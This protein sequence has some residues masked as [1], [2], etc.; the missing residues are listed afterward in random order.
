MG[1]GGL[2]ALGKVGVQQFQPDILTS[3]ALR[4]SVREGL[5]GRGQPLFDVLVKAG[6]KVG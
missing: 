1:L 6:E 2:V 5:P 3:V 4:G